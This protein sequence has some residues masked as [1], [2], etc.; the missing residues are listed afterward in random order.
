MILSHSIKVGLFSTSSS[1]GVLPFYPVLAR[2]QICSTIIDTILNDRQAGTRTAEAITF[3]MESLGAA[4][5]LPIENSQAS[6][7]IIRNALKIYA[8]WITTC[9]SSAKPFE[10]Q[11]IRD[12]TSHISLLFDRS[13]Y[14]NSASSSNIDE[15]VKIVNAALDVFTTLFRNRGQDL[16]DDTYSHCIRVYLGMCDS[17]LHTVEAEDIGSKVAQQMTR[18]MFER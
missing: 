4:F 3:A 1:P 7:Q 11:F 8:T 12:I 5:T 16:D 13:Q 6:I 9:P 15:Y 18:Q 2:R 17:F 10:P 14:S